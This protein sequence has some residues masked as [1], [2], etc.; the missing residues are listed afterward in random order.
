MLEAYHRHVQER[1]ALD[2]PPLPLDAEQTAAIVQLLER[3]P[4]GAA[5]D[6][7]DLLARR[8]PPGVNPAARLKAAFLTAVAGGTITSPAV[9]P[10]RAV[11]LL[12][13]MRGGFNLPPLLA[14]LDHPVLAA[15]AAAQLA[16]TTLVFDALH[17]VASRA[18]AG[19]PADATSHEAP[20]SRDRITPRLLAP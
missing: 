8:V 20:I 10:G 19:N 4:P 14:L 2:L 9:D 12:G 13:G 17:E 7:I 18:R 16:H 5:H 15:A 11:E 1:A 3:P 6:L